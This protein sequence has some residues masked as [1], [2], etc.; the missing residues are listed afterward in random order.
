[1]SIVFLHMVCSYL[2][3]CVF[4]LRYL[5]QAGEDGQIAGLMS[6]ATKQHLVQRQVLRK[7]EVWD[8]F[9]TAY[10]R[11][12]DDGEQENTLEM[13]AARAARAKRRV[14]E[15]QKESEDFE[16][17]K[18]IGQDF[19][20]GTK[21]ANN[22]PG[23]DDIEFWDGDDGAEDKVNMVEWVDNEYVGLLYDL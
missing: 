4:L 15:R 2:H 18:L 22:D 23:E 10:E 8:N 11:H 6:D 13:E 21:K 12:R 9:L 19:E 14:R 3:D 5:R 17:A 16:S 1:M 20:L 7:D